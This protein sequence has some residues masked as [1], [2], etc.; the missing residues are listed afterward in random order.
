MI[1]ACKY[2]VALTELQDI[3]ENW[4][5]CFEHASFNVLR[6]AIGKPFRMLLE[7]ISQRM[8][9]SD[10]EFCETIFLYMRSQKIIDL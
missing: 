10:V 7:A 8:F 1:H 9:D 4:F 2:A 3:N 6:I 5:E